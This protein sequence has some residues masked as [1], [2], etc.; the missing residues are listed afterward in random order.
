MKNSTFYMTI[1]TLVLFLGFYSCGGSSTNTPGKTVITLYETMKNKEFEKTA[2]MYVT[3]DGEK[4]SKDELKKIEGMIGMGSEEFEKKG[5]LDHVIINE[6]KI[7]E[8][9]N[10]AKV[11]FTIHFKNGDTDDDIMNLDKIN[12]NWLIKVSNY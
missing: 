1:L 10:S 9:G 7:S 11:Y 3:K 8:E 4:L 6:E 2:K 5:G 12:N